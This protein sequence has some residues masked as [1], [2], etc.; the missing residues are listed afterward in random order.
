M[1]NEGVKA[2]RIESVRTVVAHVVVKGKHSFAAPTA[3]ATRL[4]APSRKLNRPCAIA[5]YGLIPQ[6]QRAGHRARHRARQ[7]AKQQHV[8]ARLAR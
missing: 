8:T 5:P 7:R 3:R 2:K 1:T 6:W 4:A